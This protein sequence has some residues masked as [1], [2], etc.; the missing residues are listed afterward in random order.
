MF[1]QK[2]KLNIIYYKIGLKYLNGDRA[3]KIV[4]SILFFHRKKNDYNGSI[5]IPEVNFSCWK[6]VMKYF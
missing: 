3:N 6:G 4:D 5:F 2:K 1:W